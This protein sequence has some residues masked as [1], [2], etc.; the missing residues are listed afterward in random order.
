MTD[1]ESWR[2]HV[3]EA[4]KVSED[5]GGP[6]PVLKG[7]TILLMDDGTVRWDPSLGVHRS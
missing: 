4:I 1:D 3:V 2:F 6:Y 7:A 5:I